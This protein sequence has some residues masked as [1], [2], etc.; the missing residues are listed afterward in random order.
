MRSSTSYQSGLWAEFYAR[1]Y[2]RLH[3]FRIV[4]SRY[5]TG[6]NTNRAEIDIIARRKNLIIFVEVKRRKNL[7]IAFG[8]ITNAQAARLRRA[9]ETYLSQNRWMG[10]AR[11]DVIAVCGHRIH[12]VKNVI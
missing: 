11:F 1:M 10:D 4:R 3:G 6:R 5:I 7:D 9:A 2:L 12:W 8:A